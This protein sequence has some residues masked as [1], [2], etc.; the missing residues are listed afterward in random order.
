[1]PMRGMN[2][3]PYPTPAHAVATVPIDARAARPAVLGPGLHLRLRMV[4]QRGEA[5]V[6]HA[7]LPILAQHHVLRLE[8]RDQLNS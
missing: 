8:V 1:M 7:H 4:V 6:Q 3:I 2:W 5:E